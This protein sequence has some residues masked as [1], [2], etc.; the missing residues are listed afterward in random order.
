[1][2]AKRQKV[3]GYEKLKPKQVRAVEAF[4]GARKDVFVSLPTGYGKSLCFGLLPRVFDNIRGV[5]E[6]SI[7]IVISPLVSLI[8]DQCATFNNMGLS[9]VYV[10]SSDNDARR[11]MKE[12]EYQLLFA[13]P[14]DF[15]PVAFLFAN[16]EREK[17]LQ[18]Y[19]DNTYSYLI[20]KLIHAEF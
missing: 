5:K 19:K 13:C 17:F 15:F 3:L 11:R 12:E 6:R 14:E 10:G 16:L 1:M 2:C 7:T 8:Q 20:L 18:R 4:V 9:A